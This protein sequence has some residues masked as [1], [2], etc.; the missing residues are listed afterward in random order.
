MG[1]FKQLPLSRPPAAVN[2]GLPIAVSSDDETVINVSLF[3]AKKTIRNVIETP[4][5]SDE[6]KRRQL[7]LLERHVA[8]VRR[9][10]T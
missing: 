2:S 1:W 9:R 3:D 4:E 10:A 8:M 6:I 7:A 5:R